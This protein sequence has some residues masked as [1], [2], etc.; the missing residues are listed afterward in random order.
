MTAFRELNP[1]P[2]VP[3]SAPTPPSC[4]TSLSTL[5]AKTKS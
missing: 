3:V 4:S 5:H 2:V 1:K